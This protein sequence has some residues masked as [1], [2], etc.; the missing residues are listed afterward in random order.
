MGHLFSSESSWKPKTQPN[1]AYGRHR[2]WLEP[3][4]VFLFPWNPKVPVTHFLVNCVTGTFDFSRAFFQKLSRARPKFY[5]HFFRNCHGQIEKFTG[6]LK[7]CCHGHFYVCHGHFCALISFFFI[8]SSHNKG[9]I[10]SLNCRELT[11]FSKTSTMPI[12]LNYP[13]D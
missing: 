13:P 5:G 3:I 6:I 11:I 12:K 9:D 1:S 7:N 10:W 2:L 4:S 8:Y